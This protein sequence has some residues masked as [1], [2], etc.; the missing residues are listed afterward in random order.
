MTKYDIRSFGIGAISFYVEIL[1]VQVKRQLYYGILATQG[2]RLDVVLSYT[3]NCTRHCV[4]KLVDESLP[5]D[6]L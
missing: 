6:A 5:C 1:V 4:C 2:C 3:V